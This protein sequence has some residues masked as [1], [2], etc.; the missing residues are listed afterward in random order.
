MK[1]R[2]YTLQEAV[3]YLAVSLWSV[4]CLRWSG[5]LPSV[6]VQGRRVLIDVADMDKLIEEEKVFE[7]APVRVMK[8]RKVVYGPVSSKE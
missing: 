1:K 4:R 3:E 6:R 8:A 7:V 2:L 5:R